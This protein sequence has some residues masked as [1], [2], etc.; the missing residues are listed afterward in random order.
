[1]T[2]Y[3]GPHFIN[4]QVAEIT[5]MNPKTI[6]YHSDRG[7]VIPSFSPGKGKGSNRVYSEGDCLKFM[8]IPVLADHGLSLKKI[9]EVFKQ[10]QMNLLN[11]SNPH[12]YHGLPWRRALLGIYNMGT[13]DLT[14]VV[15]FPPDPEKS[16][17]DVKRNFEEN[18]TNFKVDMLKHKSVLVIDITEYVRRLPK[19]D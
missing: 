5:G 13:E 3:R 7:L 17:P 2:K 6:A 14:A 10:V 15:V 12:L 19:V 1:M 8:L 16:Q 18:L 9:G 11:P 4:K